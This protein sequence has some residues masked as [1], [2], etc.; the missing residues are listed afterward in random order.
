MSRLKLF[1]PLVLLGSILLVACQPTEVIVTEFVDREVEVVVTQEVEVEV[2]T[3]V[4]QEIE[5]VVTQKVEV[6]KI[7]EVM[8]EFDW[9]QFEG[10]TIRYLSAE[11][12]GLT[13]TLNLVSEFEDLTGI[14]VEIDPIPWAEA[15]T[16]R[17]L[18]LSSGSDSYDAMAVWMFQEK[19]QYLTNGWYEPLNQYIHNP[20]LTNPDYDWDDFG[21]IGRFWADDDQ[22][23]VWAIPTKFDL[24][25]MFARTSV[26][27]EHGLDF[28]LT[29]SELLEAIPIV[30]DPENGLYAIS[31]RGLQLQNALMYSWL[32]HAYGGAWTDSGGTLATFGEP[33][34]RAVETYAEMMQ[35]GPPGITGF[36]WNDARTAFGQGQAVFFFEGY[37]GSYAYMQDPEVAKIS[38]DVSYGLLPSEDPQNPI[39]P[40][41]QLGVMINPN[42]QNK[43]AAWLFVQW[44]TSKEAHLRALVDVGDTW[45]RKST[46]ENQDFLNS[47]VYIE[48]WASGVRD[49]LSKEALNILPLLNNVAE[50]RDE[51][52]IIMN[53]AVQD[54]PNLNRDF[55]AQRL[56][57]TNQKFVDS[58]GE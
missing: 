38:G 20:T 23:E 33:G 1:L 36:A 4:T 13:A 26:L 3:I 2:E 22:G 17:V 54:W 21:P 43:E 41:S 53:E 50:W 7:V 39:L 32:H 47:P 57:D 14:E 31:A 56:I 55:I 37:G 44:L 42:S 46:Y 15:I 35:F 19:L 25:G 16:K 49:A 52:G 24:W 18:E 9:R 40:S 5:V 34:I 45:T 29:V 6:E 27:E 48:E 58:Q 51:Y 11:E 12:P 30:H 8:K 28:P 10:T